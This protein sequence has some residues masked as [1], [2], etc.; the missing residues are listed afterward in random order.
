MTGRRKLF[1]LVLCV[2]IA[3]QLGAGICLTVWDG[4]HPGRLSPSTRFG[5]V[6]CLSLEQQLP[7]VNLDAF[8]LCLAQRWRTGEVTFIS[9]TMTF[10]MA[11]PSDS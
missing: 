3:A 11:L 2:L 9:I 10:G 6:S 5:V 7:E 8:K 1:G 4:S